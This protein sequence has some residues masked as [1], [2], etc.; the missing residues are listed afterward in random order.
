MNTILPFEALTDPIAMLYT[1]RKADIERKQYY[2]ELYHQTWLT[3]NSY[4][5]KLFTLETT[6]LA[7]WNYLW[8][9]LELYSEPSMSIIFIERWHS[10]LTTA[11]VN[12][13][14]NI[15]AALLDSIKYWVWP[16][17]KE[18]FY[19]ALSNICLL[20]YSTYIEN[21][22]E[23]E[24][25]IY[26]NKPKYPGVGYTKI[27]WQ[28]M[29][30]TLVHEYTPHSKTGLLNQAKLWMISCAFNKNKLVIS[31]KPTHIHWFK[32]QDHFWSNIKK[33]NISL[34]HTLKMMSH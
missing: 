26:N 1:W 2:A 25:S 8:K 9:E 34:E 27:N 23:Y 22:S 19:I 33:H 30:Y 16:E 4:I 24:N 15:E 3:S 14:L 29:V 6:N 31:T 13:N 21:I 17:N 10:A 5:P 18:N 7:H 32:D 28:D 12:K 20:D 11:R